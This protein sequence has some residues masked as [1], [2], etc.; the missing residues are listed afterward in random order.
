MRHDPDLYSCDI[1]WLLTEADASIGYR[2]SLGSQIATLER[3][4]QSGLYDPGCADPYRDYQVSS[5]DKP[6]CI[7][8]Y[9]RLWA[10]WTRLGIQHRTVLSARYTAVCRAQTRTTGGGWGYT[11][12]PP[13][14]ASYLGDL[15]GVVLLL[16]ADSGAI[17][18][19]L[20]AAGKGNVGELGAWLKLA[21]EASRA[22]HRAFREMGHA[23]WMEGAHAAA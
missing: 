14:V 22:A 9:R 7:D 2:S 3:G 5:P 16:A 18:T 10:V 1:E 15:A 4:G 13:G 20:T 8:R 23:Q 19:V 17:E 12:F 21:T 6:G 11:N